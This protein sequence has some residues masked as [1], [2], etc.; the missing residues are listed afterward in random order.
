MISWRGNIRGHLVSSAADR[1]LTPPALR[2]GCEI[3]TRTHSEGGHA[4][5]VGRGSELAALDA[6][7][8]TAR[9]GR[10]VVTLLA[11]EPGIG[12]TRLADELSDRATPL[13]VLVLWGRCYEGAGAPAFWPWVQI[14]RAYVQAR[15]PD[16]LRAEI[17]AGAA[18]LAAVAPEVR[19]LLPETP[20]T[21]PIEGEQARFRLFDSLTGTLVRASH[22]QPLLL[23]I[24]DLH[25][26]DVPSLLLVRHLARDVPANRILLVGT[27]RESEIDSMHSLTAAI[28]DLA[29][30]D[31]TLH[32]PLTGLTAVEITQLITMTAGW[33]PSETLLIALMDATVGNPFF[34]AQL[35]RLLVQSQAQDRPDAGLRRREALPAGVRAAITQRLQR[36][37]P[38]CHRLL[39]VA[40]VVGREFSLRVLRDVGIVSGETL[41]DALD[42]AVHAHLIT[43]VP[44]VLGSYR[45]IH[46]LVRETLY[47]ALPLAER[48]WLH[49]QVGMTLATVYAAE[50]DEHLAELADHFF[51]AAPGG[52]VAT[53]LDYSVQAA[54]RSS[55]LLAYEDA[56][57]HYTRALQLL[58]LDST[59]GP[60]G[61]CDPLLELGAVQARSGAMQRSRATYEQAAALARQ[62]ADAPRLAQA[63]LGL[64]GTVVTPGVVDERVIALLTEALAALEAE[65]SVVRTRVLG[66]LAMEYRYSPF[67]ERR[68]AL[69]AEAVALAR[70]LNDSAAL[71]A[72]RIASITIASSASLRI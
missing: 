10:G 52:D 28:A 27:Y 40:T 64:A 6:A 31:T 48:I 49:R 61:R 4:R 18:D 58:D 43:A 7:L 2:R 37:A 20:L 42:E 14:V 69:S 24:D 33:S 60:L 56:A 25:W 44:A 39:Q 9:A 34:V 47:D 55:H 41:L 38:A 51:Q 71:A 68:D 15:D 59:H 21:L 12:K 35:A 30:L 22:L 16:D 1:S 70:R 46:A 57:L 50:P 32:L 63:A 13:G 26:A 17:R 72:A 8:D 5:F 19:D 66:R 62:R 36:L 65:D 53:A 3:V 54:R 45:F 67:R 11:G 29:R 23:V